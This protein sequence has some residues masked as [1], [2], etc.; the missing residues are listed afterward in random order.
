MQRTAVVGRYDIRTGK[1][2][3]VSHKDMTIIPKYGLTTVS[4]Y[5]CMN[6]AY[7]PTLQAAAS[8]L[9]AVLP[10]GSGQ[11]RLRTAFF[12]FFSLP[13]KS[14]AVSKSLPH[15]V[16][17]GYGASEASCLYSNSINLRPSCPPTVICL[18]KLHQGNSTG[19][20]GVPADVYS[21]LQIICE[22]M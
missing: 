15:D 6:A 22:P 10:F 11:R 4:T 21:Y 18:N 9:P 5:L 16:M 13:M 2:T 19:G 7:R 14:Q 20:R 1:C 12:C 8:I 3:P 17:Q